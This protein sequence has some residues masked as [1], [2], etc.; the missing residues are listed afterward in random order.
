MFNAEKDN[1][2]TL[3]ANPETYPLDENEANTVVDALQHHGA[4]VTDLQW[5]SEGRACDIF[6]AV[7]GVDEAREMATHL[8]SE[9]PFDGIIQPITGR[10]KKLLISDMDSTMIQQECIDELAEFAG[11]KE[12]ISKITDRAMNGELDFEEALEERVALLKGL[13]E[14]VLQRAF[15][16]NIEYMP[17]A[18]ELVAT[19]KANGA[20]C[21]LVSGGFTYFTSRVKDGLGFDVDEANILEIKDGRLTGEVRKPVLDKQ[22]KV[23]ALS[24]Y[25]EK[26]ALQQY[27]T[28]AV[29]DGANDLPMLEAAGLGVAYHAKPA[30]RAAA[31]SKI[32]T[33]DLSALLYA[34]GYKEGEIINDIMQVA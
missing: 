18:K 5:L 31:G 34:Q 2:F 12:K 21:V 4:I 22:S 6:F 33:C 23:D 29:G 3:I 30:V 7:L 19:M 1:V 11:L 10:R 9:V 32:D 16:E 17:G 14:D 20:M 13:P 26:Y 28:L 15:D 27:Q 25:T 8:L 24:F